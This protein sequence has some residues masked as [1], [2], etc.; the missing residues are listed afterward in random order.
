MR[1]PKQAT[2]PRPDSGKLQ[3]GTFQNNSGNHCCR[4]VNVTQQKP[5]QFNDGG[6]SHIQSDLTPIHLQEPNSAPTLLPLNRSSA[7]VKLSSPSAFYNCKAGKQA[8]HESRSE[9]RQL[10]QSGKRDRCHSRNFSI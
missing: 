1:R 3:D 7:V 6:I 4:N 10:R 9:Q 8:N 2:A 5:L